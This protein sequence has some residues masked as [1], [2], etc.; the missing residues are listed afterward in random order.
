DV[1]FVDRL[2]RVIARWLRHLRRRPH[3]GRRVLKR[4]VAAM[5]ELAEEPCA[6]A[7]DRFGDPGQSR[8]HGWIPGIDE[9][10]G[11]LS[12]GMHRLALENDE[13]HPTPGSLLMI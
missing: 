5:G 2:G 7:V 4:G 6:V 10:T 12:R 8:H 3:D 13:P 9:A 1:V 11:H